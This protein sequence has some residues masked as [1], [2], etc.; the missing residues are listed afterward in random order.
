[1]STRDRSAD[2]RGCGDDVAAYA[3]GALDPAEAEAFRAH[4]KTCAACREELAAFKTVVDVLPMG[5][6]QHRAPRR[7]RRRVMSAV[8]HD[9]RERGGQ[10]ERRR[11][12]ALGR[13]VSRPVL[14]LG[15]LVVAA[16][17][18]VGAIVIGNSGSSTR[19]FDAKVIGERG[20]A[21]V[22][23]TDGR[24]HLIVRDFSPPP[25]GK[26]YEVWLSRSGQKPT[27]TGVLFTV[28]PSGDNNVD[29]GRVHGADAV[30][31]TPEP[32]GGSPGP[33]H[34]PVIDAPLS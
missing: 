13:L 9:V 4:L 20:S 30:L 14:A 32:K 11:R 6:P 16:V 1:M 28:T 5:A 15:A 21:K 8:E 10:P 3:L 18:A 27:P 24:A 34:T 29:V 22:A 19:V 31:V 26:V 23:V 17:I 7:L 25:A 33:T 12:P 2:P